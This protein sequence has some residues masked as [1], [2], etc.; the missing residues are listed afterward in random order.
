[1]NKMSLECIKLAKKINKA[2][3]DIIAGKGIM[4]DIDNLDEMFESS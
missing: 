4:I 3:A 2:R 1:M